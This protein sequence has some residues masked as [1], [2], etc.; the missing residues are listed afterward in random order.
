MF[1]CLAS[2]PNLGCHSVISAIESHRLRRQRGQQMDLDRFQRVVPDHRES[3]L[4]LIL[5]VAD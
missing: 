1:T 5:H 2:R 4:A 3:A